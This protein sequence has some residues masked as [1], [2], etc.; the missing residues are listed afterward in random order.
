MSFVQSALIP[1]RRLPEDGQILSVLADKLIES[2]RR[3][4]HNAGKEY[5]IMFSGGVDSL[6]IATLSP[7]EIP[8]YTVGVD[9][10]HDL[11]SAESAAGFIGRKLRT[12]IVDREE[13]IKYAGELV[14]R[15]PDIGLGE[16]GYETVLMAACNN[17]E[18]ATIMTGQGADELFFGYRRLRE[19][20]GLFDYY[21]NR[22]M[23]RTAP[24]ETD[25]CKSF[26]KKLLNPYLSPEVLSISA[27]MRAKIDPSFY[28]GKRIVR[29]ALT[30]L[31]IP[32]NVAEKPKKAAQFGSGFDKIIRK[33][34]QHITGL[35]NSG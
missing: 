21:M 10:S 4:L 18:E 29:I 22:L 33:N 32:G 12:V 25:L 13:I 20:P 26:G 3:T 31:G 23:K 5:S 14:L 9:G 17:I 24:R 15:F 19:N 1:V 2:V 35:K 34:A 27:E 8:L 7:S 30:H 11:V 28:V 16:L 6:L